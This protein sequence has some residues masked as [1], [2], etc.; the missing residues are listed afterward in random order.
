MLECLLEGTTGIDEH[1]RMFRISCIQTEKGKE[2]GRTLISP[3]GSQPFRYR[4]PC[5]IASEKTT[6]ID[7]D[8]EQAARRAQE[9]LAEIQRGPFADVK[10][11]DAKKAVSDI[12]GS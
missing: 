5:V 11:F 3:L 6:L 8:T 2:C 10:P 1:G 12:V 9:V 4:V 7:A